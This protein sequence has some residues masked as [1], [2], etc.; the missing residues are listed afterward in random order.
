MNELH[1][2]SAQIRG[3]CR[4]LIL[5]S[6]PGTVSLAQAQY[7]AHPRNRFWPVMGQLCGFD[8]ALPYPQRL[9]ALQAAGVGLWDVL[10]RCR[11]QGSL[12]AAIERGSEQVVPLVE[13]LPRLPQLRAIA[14]NGATSARLFQRH[15][16]PELIRLRP[17]LTFFSLPSTSPAHA[18]IDLPGLLARW[19][20]LLPV[21]G[22][23]Q[24]AAL[25]H[26]KP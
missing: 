17:G 26:K 10:E 14:C 12:D 3:D 23:T 7:Y 5:G 6:M 22:S 8:P 21:L 20:V 2:L 4:L 24:N 9:A 16:A 13:L 15:L 19:Q 18:A 11:R 1:N 25:A